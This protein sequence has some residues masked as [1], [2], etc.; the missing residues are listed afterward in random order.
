MFK[1]DI[2]YTAIKV[3]SSTFSTLSQGWCL[4]ASDKSWLWFSDWSSVFNAKSNTKGGGSVLQH[5][6]TPSAART[7][8]RWVED[9]ETELYQWS[10][11]DCLP[12]TPCHH[13]RTHV[14]GQTTK[15]KQEKGFCDIEI[16]VLKT[17]DE[18]SL[19]IFEGAVDFLSHFPRP[20]G[21]FP[22]MLTIKPKFQK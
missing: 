14:W 8:L 9:V 2:M 1:Q 12:A 5:Q 16:K 15:V 17:L 10:R 22:P 4:S 3:N 6:Q 18:I 19:G 7:R 20:A 21:R 13:S 11:P